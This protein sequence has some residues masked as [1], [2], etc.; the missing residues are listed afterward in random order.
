MKKP[1]TLSEIAIGIFAVILICTFAVQLQFNRHIGSKVLAQT[2]VT[3]ECTLDGNEYT[4]PPR[5]V[6][7]GAVSTHPDGTRWRCLSNCQEERM[8]E[9]T[10]NSGNPGCCVGNPRAGTM[11]FDKTKSKDDCADPTADQLTS[12]SAGQETTLKW[13][14][15]TSEYSDALLMHGGSCV[16]RPKPVCGNYLLEK[17][18]EECEMNIPCHNGAECKE[19]SCGG[20][21]TLCGNGK[22]ELGEECDEGVRNTNAENALCRLDCKRARC[23]D[24][25][26]DTLTG[27]ECDMGDSRNGIAGSGCSPYCRII[28]TEESA[29]A[30]AA[31]AEN[32]QLYFMTTAL[33]Q[34]NSLYFMV[35]QVAKW[36]LQSIL[37][38]F[39]NLQ[40]FL[41]PQE[42]WS[43]IMDAPNQ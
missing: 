24:G 4:I 14:G 20:D 19:C 3:Y 21:L 36:N 40:S 10:P 22:R 9:S 13:F 26:V 32:P 31:E 18:I 25:I 7:L 11:R 28:I 39:V 37:A 8:G 16:A 43:Q 27:E 38:P 41:F 17:P 29:V 30:P 6:T 1:L 23:G 2:I 12:M 5:C 42:I 35:T 15:D 33:Q 34:T